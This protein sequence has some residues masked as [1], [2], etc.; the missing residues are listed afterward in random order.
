MYFKHKICYMKTFI[1]LVV[2]TYGIQFVAAQNNKQFGGGQYVFSTLDDMN[3]A[4]RAE[5]K[6][7]IKKNEEIL[8]SHGKLPETSNKTA[9]V[10]LAFPLAWNDGF[11]GYNFYCIYNY[12]DHNEAYPSVITDYNCGGRS[13]DTETG[14]NH[15]GIDYVLW[16]FDWNLMADGAVKIVASAPG[17]IVAKT[18]GGFDQN[19]TF[20]PGIW[21]AIFIRHDDGSTAWYGHMKNGSLTDKELGD[22]VVTGEFLGLVGSSGNST[23]PHLHFE[24]YDGD[25]NLIDPYSGVCNDLNAESWWA[26]QPE[27]LEPGINRIQTHNAPPNFNDCPELADINEKNEFMPGDETYFAFYAKDLSSTDL[28]HLKIERADGSVWYEWDFYQPGDYIASYWY[29]WYTIPTDVSEGI[30]TWS[31]ELAGNYYEHEFLVGDLPANTNEAQLINN[32]YTKVTEGI[33]NVSIK[34]NTPFSGRI[35]ISNIS[36]QLIY[37]ETTNIYSG[38][39][40]YEIS[41]LTKATGIYMLNLL[42]TATGEN[43]TVKFNN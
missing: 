24:L 37:D 43:T 27:Y 9:A 2:F 1:Y 39:N 7:M 33:L 40:K 42:N 23:A 10:S 13:Y 15:Q 28:C 26:D 22:M 25:D 36:G 29:W 4:Q 17:M 12:L 38:L 30:W 31:C 14:Y 35:M 41:F 19:C 3:E 21:N 16:P 20:N 11:S 6:Q 34:T 32:L 18:D 8:R 5:I